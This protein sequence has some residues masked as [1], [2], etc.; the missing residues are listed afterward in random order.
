[1]KKLQELSWNVSEQQYREDPAYS[2][3]MLATFARE[4]PA[5][6]PTLKEPKSSPSLLFGAVTDCLLTKPE[7]FTSIYEIST[8]KLPADKIKTTIQELFA[9]YKNG[10]P[11]LCDINKEV[12][13]EYIMV[14]QLYNK[15]WKP[16]T[17]YE[18]F[19]KDGS[20]YYETLFIDKIF[21]SE[22]VF[23]EASSCVRSLYENPYTSIFLEGS[24]KNLESYNQ[25]KFKCDL[26]GRTVKCML[27]RIIVDHE[28]KKIL[29][30]DFKTTSAD[31]RDFKNSF[32]KWN[33][34]LQASLY[35]QILKAICTADEYFKDF[36]ICAFTFIVI[37]KTKL[38]PLIYTYKD[39][40]PEP[41]ESENNTIHKNWDEVLEDLVW[42]IDN[43]QYKYTKDECTNRGRISLN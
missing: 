36:T 42:C 8:I 32:V 43:E 28:N 9:I 35:T 21:I 12:V 25:I 18:N 37:N 39:S 15:N 29:P 24:G 1:M 2:Y 22:D 34:Y 23:N 6:I 38:A 10:N 41:F 27:D 3:S 7:E 26:N 40:Y 11:H 14:N 5:C 4:G 16:E 20:E 33:Y 17:Q 31:E 19:I 13:T 30:I